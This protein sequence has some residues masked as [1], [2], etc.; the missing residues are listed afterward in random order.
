MLSGRAAP[1]AALH[2]AA[3]AAAVSPSNHDTST[4]PPPTTPTHPPTQPPT[5]VR[6]S[7]LM[8]SV[9]APEGDQYTLGT[10]RSSEDSFLRYEYA[11]LVRA[12][13]PYSGSDPSLKV[14]S[15]PL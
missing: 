7:P 1:N 2:P 10:P 5:C 4:A 3:G 8:A 11:V 13:V 6:M 14:T 9:L 12:M 15:K